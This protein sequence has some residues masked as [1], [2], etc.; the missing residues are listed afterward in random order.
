[1]LVERETD[2]ARLARALDEALGGDGRLLFVGGEAGVGKT[3]LVRAAAE[4]ASTR[5]E[6]RRGMADNVTTS[7][8]L[9]A[10]VDA[11]P[12]LST[13]VDAAADV[14]SL[15]LFRRLRE[16]LAGTATMLILEDVHWADEATLDAIR[17]LGRRL[18]GLPLLVL[19]TYRTEQVTARQLLAAVMG[20]LATA[21][22]VGR[23]TVEPLSQAAVSTL[24]AAAGSAIDPRDLYRRTGGNAFYVSEV[25][26]AASD[27][28]PATVRDAVLA[29]VTRLTAGAQD[30][31][32]A[33]AVLGQPAAVDMLVEVSRQPSASVDECVENGLLV[34]A[35]DGWAFRHELA[36]I[37]VEQ[38]LPPG[39][40]AQ[41]NVRA[42]RA[43][44]ARGFDDDRR[45][46][47]HAAQGGDRTGAQHHATRA[48]TRARRLGAH[49]EAAEQFRLALRFH[50]GSP[51]SRG[52]LLEALSYECYL[53]DDLAEALTARH[54]A[55]E[56]AELNGDR[57]GEG[58]D[59][60]WLSRLSWFLGR[61]ADSERY[62][63][64]AIE[65][66]EPDGDGH[67]LAMA[68]SNKA[69]LCTLAGNSDGAREWGFRAIEMARRIGDRE[70][71]THALNNV[72]TA[73]IQHGETADG[74][75]LLQRSLDQALSDDAPEHA[76]RAYTN[77]GTMAA[78][79]REL[80]DADSYLRAGITYCT[81]RDLDSWRLYMSAHLAGAFAEQ[82]RYDEASAQAAYVLRHPR[83]SPISAIVASAVAAQVAIR[84]GEPADPHLSRA[85]DLAVGTGESQRLVPAAVARAE[86]AWLAGRDGAADEAL[87]VA[88]AAASAHP[89]PWE[90]GEIAYWRSVA[91]L[92]TQVS[93]PVSEPFALML[94]GRWRDAA[95]AWAS[96][97]CP[98][99]Q[100]LALAADPSLEAARHA[101]DIVD[102]L[103]APAVRTAIL[104]TRHAQGLP[105]PRGPRPA[106]R[107]NPGALTARELDVLR[108]L[109]EGLSNAD[110][111]TRLFLSERTVGHHVSAVLRKLGE[112][113]RARVVAAATRQG[114]IPAAD[115]PT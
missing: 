58:R 40:V 93:A 55:M 23:L 25:L 6:V 90:I 70:T 49:R 86:A 26:A 14:T 34:R 48:A 106:S 96:R 94:D 4:R 13:M 78:Q 103:G 59:Q 84:R 104:R 51:A 53:T 21:P 15:D 114:L 1:M 73:L 52:E 37:A 62:A 39:I 66:L 32:A 12:E 65:T 60:R 50:D 5:V 79:C 74:R 45:L 22:G 33:A 108:C 105:V 88:W 77:L 102:R 10:L 98:M 87:D 97:D 18:T 83:L 71:E 80:A 99:W 8:A 100:A 89:S 64:R 85:W 31:L 43:L 16:V 63:L 30:V 28:T 35:Q 11:V 41:L 101:V 113:T 61:N 17:F 42:Y 92:P 38:T 75:A 47:H 110:I 115:G 112:P 19:V 76:A 24:A 91:G 72:G 67:E 27:E 57:A 7:A 111:A 56:L 109:A 36:R 107:A 29:R 3:S 69:Q 68:Y 54:K 82:G 81:D 9:G 44:T 95:D 46:A 2:L 20:D